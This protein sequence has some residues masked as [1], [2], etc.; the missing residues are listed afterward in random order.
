MEKEVDSTGRA[1][2]IEPT[3]IRKKDSTNTTL[4]ANFCIR[5]VRVEQT[6]A[7]VA[8]SSWNTS[9]LLRR[10]MRS[11]LKPRSSPFREENSWSSLRD[12]AFIPS[13]NALRSRR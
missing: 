4:L 7:A 11:S 3:R 2:T 12:D 13:S 8:P 10:L 1:K 5:L 6:S 9:S